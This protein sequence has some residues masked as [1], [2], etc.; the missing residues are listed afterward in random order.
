MINIKMALRGERERELVPKLDM[1]KRERKYRLSKKKHPTPQ[2]HKKS[3]QNVS[4]LSCKYLKL[5]DN[6][7]QA[8]AYFKKVFREGKEENM[9]TSYEEIF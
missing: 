6:G 1:R 5:Y 2:K 4:E 8:H 9:C 7:K 3:K